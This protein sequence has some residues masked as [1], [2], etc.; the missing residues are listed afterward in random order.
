MAALRSHLQ[1]QAVVVSLLAAESRQAARRSI[2]CVL[3]A[4][5]AAGSGG[6]NCYL[7]GEG[8][9]RGQPVPSGYYRLSTY[10]VDLA[11]PVVAGI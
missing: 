10:G 3:V 8:S 2:V 6:I 7:H 5:G 11:F 1:E 4:A 9:W